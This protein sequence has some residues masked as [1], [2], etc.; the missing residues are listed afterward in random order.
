MASVVSCDDEDADGVAPLRPATARSTIKSAVAWGAFLKGIT[1]GATSLAAIQH[2]GARIARFVGSRIPPCSKADKE[3]VDYVRTGAVA[4]IL[5]AAFLGGRMDVLAW[6]WDGGL[7]CGFDR[8]TFTHVAAWFLAHCVS[9]RKSRAH[10]ITG[11][12]FAV[13]ADMVDTD[14]LLAQLQEAAALP[15]VFAHEVGEPESIREFIAL[16]QAIRT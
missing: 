15:V 12:T 16:I 9:L 11:I 2:E 5:N 4:A 7:A 6:I 3:A 10:L 1:S 13:R 14:V 8:A